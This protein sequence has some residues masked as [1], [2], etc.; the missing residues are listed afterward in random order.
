VNKRMKKE[1]LNFLYNSSMLDEK[2]WIDI[3]DELYGIAETL[4]PKV[5]TI[6]EN[7]GRERND[8]FTSA[9]YMLVSYSIENYL[10]ALIISNNKTEY[11]KQLNNK[12]EL[13]QEINGHDLCKLAGDAGIKEDIANDFFKQELLKKLTYCAIWFGRYPVPKKAEGFNDR[14]KSPFSSIDNPIIKN[15]ITIIKKKVEKLQD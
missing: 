15:I 2:Q 3:A 9:Y 6:Q 10:K 13:P 5:K 8:S 12:S 14:I 7:A 4:E 1:N 11:K